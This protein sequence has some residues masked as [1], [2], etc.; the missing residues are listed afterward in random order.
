MIIKDKT[1]E[2]VER[3]KAALELSGDVY[4][5][6]RNHIESL[7]SHKKLLASYGCHSEATTAEEAE[8]EREAFEAERERRRNE[9]SASELTVADTLNMLRE[10]GVDTDDQ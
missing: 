4:I 2:K 1:D 10:L 6:G 9:Q 7:D 3:I 5:D 8:A